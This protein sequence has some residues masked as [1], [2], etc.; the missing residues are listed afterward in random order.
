M[1]LL[2]TLLL[3]AIVVLLLP[4]D[5]R[6]Q[7]RLYD[8]VAGVAHWT[9]TFCD[10][11]LA[12]CDAASEAWATFLQKAE[13]GAKMAADMFSKHVL[14]QGEDVAPANYAPAQQPPRRWEEPAGYA[15][16]Q[17]PQPRGTLSDHDLAPN[18]RGSY[19]RNNG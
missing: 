4:T 16:Q 6:E 15:P 1:S 7:E 17:R 2:R 14:K 3:L 10:R 13:F 5:Q 19:A 8:K 12:T 18:W 9:A 11:N